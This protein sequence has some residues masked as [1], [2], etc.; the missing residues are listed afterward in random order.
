[1]SEAKQSSGPGAGGTVSLDEARRLVLAQARVPTDTCAEV[2][3][4]DALGR[5]LARDVVAT[6]PWPTTDRAA[7]DGFALRTDGTGARAGAR[8]HVVGAA[9][10]GH[11][12]AAALGAGEAVRIMTGGVVPAGADT[13]VRV[14]DSDGFGGAEVTISADVPAGAN[15]R[16]QGSEVAAGARLLARG[17]RIAASEVAALA[18]LGVVRVPVAAAPRVAIVST[19]DEV[20]DVASEPAPHQVRDS[21]SWALAAKAI[22]CGALPTRLGIV[23]DEPAALRTALERGLAHDVLLTIGGVSKGTHDL[24]HGTLQQLGVERL[25]HGVAVKPGHPTFFGVREV[26]GAVRCLVLGLPG[27]PASSVTMFELLGAPLLRALAGAEPVVELRARAAGVRFRRNAREQL[28]PAA[29]RVAEDGVLEAVLAAL[30]PS[31]DP[32]GLLD[33]DGFARVPADADPAALREVRFVPYAGGD[34]R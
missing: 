16:P 9:L 1:M 22:E 18:A 29:L 21:N 10:A 32:F 34:R 6:G 4:L 5:T 33:G 27:N 25:F 15:I 20:V 13:V 3:L 23:A 7:M 11:P 8:F 30:R 28:I 31:G 2:P 17:R 12:F 24:V 19:G 26:A 14:E